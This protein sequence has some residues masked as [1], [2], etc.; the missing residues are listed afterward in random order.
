MK[1]DKRI[2][3]MILFV[4]VSLLCPIAMSPVTTANEIIGYVFLAPIL[5]YA[6]GSMTNGLTILSG[7][8]YWSVYVPLIVPLSLL[9]MIQ[10][11]R[12]MKGKTPQNR[13]FYVGL[14]SLTFPGLFLTWMQIPFFFSGLYGYAGPFPIQFVLGM[15]L[16][17]N[18]GYYVEKLEWPDTE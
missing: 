6:Y 18:Y 13:V 10:V 11:L 14:L 2:G 1:V 8:Y 16:V 15:K 4:L 9:F 17:S 7:I 12:S 3:L 5:A